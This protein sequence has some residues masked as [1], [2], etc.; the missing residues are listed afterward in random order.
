MAT[1]TATAKSQSHEA[2]F[3]WMM[4]SY[5]YGPT[6]SYLQPVPFQE[7]AQTQIEL[8]IPRAIF[9]ITKA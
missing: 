6:L 4:V 9:M 1:E 7:T 3:T 5:G 8:S 2:E